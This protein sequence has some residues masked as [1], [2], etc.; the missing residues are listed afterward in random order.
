MHK[1]YL[2]A[3]LGGN[4][5]RNIFFMLQVRDYTRGRRVFSEGESAERLYIVKSGEFVLTVKGVNK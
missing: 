2:F 3:E 4:S 1:V 5:I